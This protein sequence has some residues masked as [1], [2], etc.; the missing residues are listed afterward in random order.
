[1]WTDRLA[2]LGYEVADFNNDGDPHSVE[3]L[4]GSDHFWQLTTGRTTKLEGK[5]RAVET[6]VGWTLHGPVEGS[7]ESAQCTQTVALRTSV[8]ERNAA[9][10]LTKFWTLESIGAEVNWPQV[11]P[12]ATFNEVELEQRKE[13]SALPDTTSPPAGSAII[14]LKQYE[15]FRVDWRVGFFPVPAEAAL[16]EERGRDNLIVSFPPVRGPGAWS[17]CGCS[18]KRRTVFATGAVLLDVE[19]NTLTIASVPHGFR[20]VES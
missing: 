13:T 5:L 3:L 4:I 12:V 15:I 7:K 8:I 1:M 10:A 14:C 11:I 20:P 2:A 19:N 18:L 6:V 17:D 16:H 9:D